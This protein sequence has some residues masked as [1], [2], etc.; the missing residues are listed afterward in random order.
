MMGCCFS[1]KVKAESPTHNGLNS[2]V[3][4]REEDVS[5]GLSRKASSPHLLLTSRTEG[6]IL[7]SIN[8]KSFTIN[9]IRTATRNF[10]PDSMV[11][12]GGFGSVFKGWIDEHTLAPTKP[13]INYLGQLRHPNL[14]K[15][16]GYC[17][18]DDYRILVYEFVTKGSLDN[19][20]FRR[21]SYFQPLSWKIRMKIALDSAKGLAFL[22]SDEVEV[23]Y[24]DFK[25][26]N[27]LI[28]SDYNAKLS[29]FGMAKDGPEGGKSHVSTRVMGTPGYA[30]PEYLATG[31]LT[32][33]SD[34][35]SFGVVLLEI[36]SGKR[37][38]DKNR[39]TKEHNLVEW[40]KPLL[41]SKRKIFQV[42]DARIEGQYSTR[43][44][45]KVAQIAMQCM[46]V[47]QKYRPNID[48][49]VRSLEQLQDLNDKT[50]GISSSSSGLDQCGKSVD[51]SL[52]GEGSSNISS[53]ASPLR[54]S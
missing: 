4:G 23:I 48:E 21:A 45:M 9:E 47:E 16:V 37:V 43:E 52:T 39:P 35:Y 7:Q 40:A 34:V 27:I 3:G 46:S 17:L 36:M 51:E 53:S 29:D 38:L 2:K 42:M 22:H 18:E 14:V 8:L 20:L 15:L 28:D 13:E 1:A 33:K 44:A 5:S 54:S 11:G 49:V 30:A 31:H 50:N 24:R 26:S 41:I 6:E 32:K 12:E 10:R 19:H 25:T